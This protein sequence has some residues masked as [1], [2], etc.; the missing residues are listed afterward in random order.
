[1]ARIKVFNTTSQSWVYADKSFGKNGIT[2]VKGVDYFTDIDR[3]DMIQEILTELGAI[4][5]YGR[6]DANNNIYLTA[7]L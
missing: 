5:V 6:I 1:M 2:P 3:K 4:P 7:A